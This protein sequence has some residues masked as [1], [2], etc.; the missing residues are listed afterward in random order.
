MGA[1]LKFAPESGKVVVCSLIVAVHLL[2]SKNILFS[3]DFFHVLLHEVWSS[4]WNMMTATLFIYLDFE[5]SD[6]F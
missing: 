2:L 3:S 1:E 6:V 5:K 4:S